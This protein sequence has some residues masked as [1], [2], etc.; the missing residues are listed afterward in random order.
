MRVRLDWAAAEGEMVPPALTIM[1]DALVAWDSIVIARDRLPD[2]Y[3][4]G[5]RY[6]REDYESVH[7]ED[8]RD[9]RA[10]MRAG[11]GD[12]EDLAAWR[13]ADLLRA[14]ERARPVFVERPRLKGG[15]RLFH[16]LVQRAD[17]SLEDPSRI[18]GMTRI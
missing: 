9:P 18:L 12:C 15:G 2:L 6:Q 5:M 3:Q 14:G 1:L 13:C 17:G 11:G 8:W 4:S 7:P 16:I 10:M